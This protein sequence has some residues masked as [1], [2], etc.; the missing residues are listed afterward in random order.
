[1]ALNQ[2]NN[3]EEMLEK[4]G[5]SESAAVRVPMGGD[6]GDEETALLLSGGCGSPQRPT[7]QTFQSLVG[8]LLW[9]DR[10]TRPDIAF[11]VHRVTQLLHAPSEG[12]SRLAKNIA[13]YLKVT[14]GL[15]LMMH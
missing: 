7:V 3:I 6:E 13:K 9:I 11:A 2:E 5:L 4:F 15:K 12:E 8:S 1:M 10:C 14:K